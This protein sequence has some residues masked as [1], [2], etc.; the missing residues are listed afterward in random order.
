MWLYTVLVFTP[1]TQLQT[2]ELYPNKWQVS[3]Q[4]WHHLLLLIPSS[5]N[6]LNGHCLWEGFLVLFALSTVCEVPNK[7]FLKVLSMW[8]SFGNVFFHTPKET[9]QNNIHVMLWHAAQHCSGSV[10]HTWLDSGSTFAVGR[11]LSPT[12]PISPGN[13]LGS[14]AIPPQFAHFQCHHWI[15]NE[16]KDSLQ[17]VKLA[18][19]L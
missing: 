16:L 14:Y 12:L 5:R 4:G 7:L 3:A 11:L 13:G 17:G 18:Q 19:Q 9:E 10:L 8:K 2:S 6:L 1:R 15:L